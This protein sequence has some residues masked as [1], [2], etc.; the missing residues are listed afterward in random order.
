MRHVAGARRG[1]SRRFLAGTVDPARAAKDQHPPATRKPRTIG[2]VYL[3]IR[4]LM[5]PGLSPPPHS[6]V[7]TCDM[8][9][10][11][12]FQVQSRL[13]IPTPSWNVLNVPHMH[14]ST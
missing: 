9:A 6:H 3:R 11:S 8:L 4:E 12:G 5:V 10:G 7:L 1:P 2:Q 14:T 13:C